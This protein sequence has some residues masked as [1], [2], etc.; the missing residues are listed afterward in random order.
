MGKD[1]YTI[2]GTILTLFIIFGCEAEQDD[3]KVKSIV[4][5]SEHKIQKAAVADIFLKNVFKKNTNG[6]NSQKLMPFYFGAEAEE[7][8]VSGKWS[9]VYYYYIYQTEPGDY[10]T[11]FN[12]YLVLSDKI[13]YRGKQRVYTIYGKSIYGE[14]SPEEEFSPYGMDFDDLIPMA[15]ITVRKKLGS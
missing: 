6:E 3:N 4:H 12:V 10:E 1:Y 15:N 9:P 8:I 11:Y 13:I 2:L 7:V 14:F 5:Q